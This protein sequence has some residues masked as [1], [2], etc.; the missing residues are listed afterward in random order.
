MNYKASKVIKYSIL[1]VFL[2]NR[3]F[4]VRPRL[5]PG[6]GLMPEYTPGSFGFPASS[7]SLRFMRKRFCDPDYIL[8][9][10]DQTAS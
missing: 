6:P 4:D 9:F 8:F 1:T 2:L 3:P 5:M 7:L 10:A